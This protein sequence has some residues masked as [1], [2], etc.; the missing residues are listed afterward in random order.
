MKNGV[1]L[2][3]NREVTG[4]KEE[5]SWQIETRIAEGALLPPGDTKE[6][7]FTAKIVI[8]A[9]GLFAEQLRDM[10]LPH[11]FKTRPKRGQYYLL[12][13]SEGTRVS[14]TIFQAPTGRGKGVLV[15]PRM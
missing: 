4:L 8:N 14:R 1:Q 6:T 12:D 5:G 7:L 9:A 2:F 13:K 15:S 11:T 10:V 3:L